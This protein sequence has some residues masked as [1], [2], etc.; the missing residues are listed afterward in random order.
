MTGTDLKGM[1]LPC[2]IAVDI[3]SL[4]GYTKTPNHNIISEKSHIFFPIF[5]RFEAIRRG[6]NRPFA[7]ATIL[8]SHCCGI[9]V[10]ASGVKTIC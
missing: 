5:A 4:S 2:V 7:F 9:P 8:L 6:R 3:Y 10:A 1:T